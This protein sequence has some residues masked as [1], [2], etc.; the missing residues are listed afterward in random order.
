ML[1]T[2]H[3]DSAAQHLAC[4]AS[5]ENTAAM[6]A[7]A[8]FVVVR[9][10]RF[11]HVDGVQ[12]FDADTLGAGLLSVVRIGVEPAEGK[13]GVVERVWEER[14]KGEIAAV[15]GFAHKAGW[16]V[17]KEV[18]EGGEERDEFVV[19]GAWADERALG[20]FVGDNGKGVWGQAWEGVVLDVRVET[21][22]RIA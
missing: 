22:S 5:E 4:V 8:P 10:V 3:W 21:F 16:R 14:A 18:V 17:E 9:G 12:A 6:G 13:R 2:A 19:V 7:I 1:I 11:F 15:S 20:R